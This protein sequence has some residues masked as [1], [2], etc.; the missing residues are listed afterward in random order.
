MTDVDF[1]QSILDIIRGD[2]DFIPEQLY[3]IAKSKIE[4]CDSPQEECL[5][6]LQDNFVRLHSANDYF[7][8]GEE[9]ENMHNILQQIGEKVCE[10]RMN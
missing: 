2:E 7:I 3:Q 5:K 10:M 4:L 1:L 6:M 9:I 8:E